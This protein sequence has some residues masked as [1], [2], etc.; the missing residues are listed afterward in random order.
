MERLR[1]VTAPV[2]SNDTPRKSSGEQRSYIFK[3]QRDV[4]MKCRVAEQAVNTLY[5]VLNLS[6]TR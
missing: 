1:R 2:N 3:Y 5:L 4:I 6:T